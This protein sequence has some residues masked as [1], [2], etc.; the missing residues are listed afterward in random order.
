M[1]LL[2]ARRV[3]RRDNNRDISH[4]SHFTS[5]TSCQC[6]SRYSLSFRTLE[7]IDYVDRVSGCRD[8]YKKVSLL[9]HTFQLTGEDLVI[10]IVVTDSCKI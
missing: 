1:R 8:T 10:A 7:C 4:L 5:I 6:D 2:D 9:T 3:I